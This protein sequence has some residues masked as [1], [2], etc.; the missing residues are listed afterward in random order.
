MPATEPS[1]QSALRKKKDA[2]FIQTLQLINTN[3]FDA[4]HERPKLL[5]LVWGL[6]AFQRAVAHGGMRAFLDL[7]EGQSFHET[8][9]WCRE[10]GATRAAAYLAATAALY[11]NGKVPRNDDRRYRIA[12][13]LVK[14]AGGASTT[15]SGSSIGRTRA[16]PKRWAGSSGSTS[17]SIA[18][19]STRPST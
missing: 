19:T 1:L 18:T 4:Y 6:A 7:E 3:Q 2:D 16:P 8:E 9:T 13:T 12:E 14:T 17:R 10:V 5:G 15:L 11:P